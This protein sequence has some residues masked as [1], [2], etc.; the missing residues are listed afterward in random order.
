[1][2]TGLGV[3]NNKT[4]PQKITITNPL[5]SATKLANNAPF[6]ERCP[7]YF[8]VTSQTSFTILNL[9]LRENE[10]Y[11]SVSQNQITMKC[12]TPKRLI[13]SFAG[14]Q[15]LSSAI[16]R[17]IAETFFLCFSSERFSSWLMIFLYK[18]TKKN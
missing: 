5:Q 17:L 4:P 13:R 14:N 11:Y 6:V 15:S 10:P 9:Q 16:H 8:F 2:L 18:T 3:R 12:G 1:M 7:C